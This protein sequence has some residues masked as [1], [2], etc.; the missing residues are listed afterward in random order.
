MK[1]RGQL[2][3]IEKENIEDA[4]EGTYLYLKKKKTETSNDYSVKLIRM[5]FGS[6]F[7]AIKKMK[8]IKNCLKMKEKN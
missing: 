1:K 3:K 7:K 8:S 5:I 6:Q 2:L 4:K